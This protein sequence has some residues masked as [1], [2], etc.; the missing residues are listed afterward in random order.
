MALGQQEKYR[1]VGDAGLEEEDMEKQDRLSAR[2]CVGG[3]L[4]P[5]PL[6]VP[7][8]RRNLGCAA[9]QL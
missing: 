5:R 9:S 8:I 7:R 4:S 1:R 3:Q 2:L 6:S